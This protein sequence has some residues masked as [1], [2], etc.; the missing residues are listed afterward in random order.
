MK[1]YFGW[2][3]SSKMASIYVH[4]S[5]RD[6]DDAILKLYG[7]KSIEKNKQEEIKTKTCVRCNEIN[8][9]DAKYCKRCG[10]SL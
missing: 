8:S 4:L 3:Q 6:V 10:F 2:T 5:G 7:K 1:E 9:F